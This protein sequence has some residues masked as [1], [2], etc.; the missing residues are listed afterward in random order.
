MA[1]PRSVTGLRNLLPP[2]EREIVADLIAAAND[3]GVAIGVVGG[4]VR[5]WHLGRALR[6]VDL[7]VEP[8][9]GAS[10]ATAGEVAKAAARKGDRLVHH[11][12]FRTVRFERAGVAVDLATARAETYS[13]PGALPDVHAGT[14]AEDLARRDFTVNAMAVPLGRLGR[15]DWPVQVEAAGGAADLAARTLRVFHSRSFHDDPTRALRAA[16]FAVRFDFRLARA[17]R[18]ALR[19]AI[20]DG[21]F[22]AVSGARYRAEF[23]R[24]FAETRVGGDPAAAL[25]WLAEAHVLQVLEPG[26]GVDAG[27]LAAIR[28]WAHHTAGQDPDAST[29]GWMLWLA[30]FPAALRRRALVRLAVTGAPSER[31]RAY[32]RLRDRV[33]RQL[34]KARGRGAI[35]RLLA[36][37]PRAEWAAIRAEATPALRRKIDRHDSQDR[38]VELPVSGDDL[39]GAGLEGPEVGRALAGIRAA[40]LDRSVKTQ[41]DALALA[42]EIARPRRRSGKTRR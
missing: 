11:R 33:L 16:R 20:R 18:T 40:V 26:L 2:A 41:A 9:E 8:R 19:D 10:Q 6:D 15:S 38:D 42:K 22:G 17:T 3:L 14:L 31:I 4:P 5:D 13:L 29:A 30:P 28:R 32:P 36:P 23:E 39:V 35:D 7:L 27:S 1:T 37:L 12:A 34:A 25:R 21:A 24:L